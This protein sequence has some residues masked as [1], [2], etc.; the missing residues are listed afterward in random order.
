MGEMRFTKIIYCHIGNIVIETEQ[1]CVL[2]TVSQWYKQ[3][4]YH[5]HIYKLQMIKSV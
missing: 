4:V 3:T 1:W 2:L 5:T